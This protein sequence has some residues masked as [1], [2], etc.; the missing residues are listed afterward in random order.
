MFKGFKEFIMR[1]N[2]VDL[3]VGVV[4]GAA[5]SGVVNSLVKDLFT[6]LISAI[7]K[8]PDFSN[9]AVTLNGVDLNYGLF[10][11]AVISF[12]IV[13]VAIYYIVVVPMRKF[14]NRFRSQQE[15]T[16]KDCPECRT[17]VPIEAIRCKNCTQLI[18][19]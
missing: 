14:T 2:V 13:A 18:E 19:R 6:P 17:E 11:N 16:T 5:F 10:L 8:M 3:A 7:A 4:I 9:L 12:L 15:P 1:G